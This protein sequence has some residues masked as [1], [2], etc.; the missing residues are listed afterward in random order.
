MQKNDKD[1]S[2][3]ETDTFTRRR[4]FGFFLFPIAF[5]PFI[6]LFTYDWHGISTL[7]IP[8]HTPTGNLIGE[9]GNWFAYLG[10]Q[11]IGLGIW[12]APPICIFAGLRLAFGKS[13]HPGRRTIG[14]LLFVFA[15]TCLLQLTGHLPT[16]STWL[17]NLNIAP[18]AGG[19]VGYLVMTRCLAHWLSPFGSGV[20]MICLMLF[21]IFFTIGFRTIIDG[22]ANLTAWAADRKAE[23]EEA[24]E[25]AA[26]EAEAE[27]QRLAD[28]AALAAREEAK[29]QRLAEKQRL[30]DEKAAKK[31]EK[32]AARELLRQQRE[33]QRR[34]KEADKLAAEEERKQLRARLQAD[35]TTTSGETL[36]WTPTHPAVA[37]T[38]AAADIPTP[39]SVPDAFPSTGSSSAANPVSIPD[40]FPAMPETPTIRPVRSVNPPAP[41]PR[42]AAVPAAPAPRPTAPAFP[43]A[44]PA[45]PS[46]APAPA[47]AAT[48]PAPTQTSEPEPIEDKGP[49]VLPSVSLLHDVPPK[50][51]GSEDPSAMAQR[52]IDTLKVFEIN[53]ELAYFVAGPVV[54]Q[55]ALQLEMGTRV[56]KVAGLQRNIQMALQATSLRIEAP[57]PGKNAV[58]IEV[59]NSKPASVSFREII[60]G[61][62]WQK[63]SPGKF[64]VPLLLG[65]DAAGNDLVADLAKLPHL[66]VAG[67]TGQGKSVCLN[68]IINGLLMC[69]TPE[70]LKLIMVDPKRVEFTSYNKLP[71]LLVPIINDTKKVVFALRSAVVEMD[72][73]LKMFAKVGCRNIVDFNNRKTVTQGDMF[74]ADEVVGG[75]PE[76][77]KTVPYIV[78]IIDEV[79]D[80]MQAAKKEV[81]PVIAR[82]TA[83][84]RATGIHLILA[85][86]RPDANIITGVIKSNIP[87]RIAFKT[88]SSIDSRTIL[89][90]TGSELLIGKGDMLFKMSDGRLL[91]AQGSYISDEEIN[92]IVSFISEHANVQFDEKLTKRLERIKEA[93]PNEDMEDDEGEGNEN[94]MPMD[95]LAAPTANGIPAPP[96]MTQSKEDTLYRRALEVLRDTKRASVSHLQRR[97][98]I[99]Y[100]HAARLVDLLEERGVISPARGAGPREILLDPEAL[101]NQMDGVV[102][103]QTT[104]TGDVLVGGAPDMAPGMPQGEI[105]SPAPSA[106]D[107]DPFGF[108]P[109]A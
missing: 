74:G 65:K 46:V 103:V 62:L 102:P 49:Y 50:T 47:V 24:A 51:A 27:A 37:P 63:N 61:E 88:S 59:P 55:Y 77:P 34:Q 2:T 79:A 28:E 17:R 66:L 7:V 32:E 10:Y 25:E 60:D 56:E 73:R 93:D 57:I 89:D 42:P 99:G 92:N 40:A 108:P 39:I 18:N 54:T 4:V 91:R 64:Q 45:F 71:H 109:E 5:F 82:L 6:A 43:T 98:C 8:P 76:I 21:S 31:A 23:A 16:V 81:E 33:E 97:M 44:A 90:A 67:A 75:D 100:N 58:G 35:L 12:F 87:G 70:Q 29:A 69:R 68:S 14:V 94:E 105:V 80:I 22:L 86:Q 36:D 41:P 101:L 13:F 53:A 9:V 84:A 95:P 3:A 1:K 52:L 83:L 85:T 48:V 38:S 107:D 26:A 106:S 19:V 72:R 20:L 78:I 30:A 11:F 96:G 104:E 15:A